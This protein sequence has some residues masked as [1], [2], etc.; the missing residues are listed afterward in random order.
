MRNLIVSAAVLAKIR[1]KHNVTVREVEQCFENKVGVYLEDERPTH[2][3]DPATLWFVA[4]T[5]RDRL[6]KVSFMFLDGNVHLKSA[7]DAEP[8]AIALYDL[9]GK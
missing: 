7:Y 4:T 3:T 2:Q 1:D 5:H 8:E 9:H 6:L